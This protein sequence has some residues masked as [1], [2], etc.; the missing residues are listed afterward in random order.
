M[1]ICK[2]DIAP[3]I[4]EINAMGHLRPQLH[5]EG[6]MKE[7]LTNDAKWCQKSTKLNIWNNSN[8]INIGQLENQF[9]CESE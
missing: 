7:E 9:Q 6:D 4:C 2:E 1:G 3:L 8:N 5:S